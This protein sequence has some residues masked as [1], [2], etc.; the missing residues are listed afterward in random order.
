MSGAHEQAS[1]SLV[2]FGPVV[3][4]KAHEFVA[5]LIR[6]RIMLGLVEDGSSLPPER[7]LMTIFGVGRRTVQD[8]LSQLEEDGLLER[9][10]GR[11]GGTFVNV[12]EREGILAG[13]VREVVAER[14]AIDEALVFRLLVEPASAAEAAIHAR[15]DDLER[16]GRA[17][18][19]DHD[20]EF[21]FAVGAATHNRFLRESVE[22]TRLALGNVIR[23]LPESPGWHRRLRREHAAVLLAIREQDP[24]GASMLM[25]D[26]IS[27]ANRSIQALLADLR[28]PDDAS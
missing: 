2:D 7:E 5:E 23:A 21:H 12:P 13:L 24:V 6:R 1:A 20:T 22:R 26:H 9:R 10:R 8:A 14:D 3:Q 16:I 11:T 28:T 27:R 4:P 17:A 15:E 19:A 25:H 18:A